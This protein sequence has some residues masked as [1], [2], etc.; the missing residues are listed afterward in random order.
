MGKGR[1][2]ACCYGGCPPSPPILAGTLELQPLL[3]DSVAI[4]TQRDTVLRPPPDGDPASQPLLPSLG[5]THF[6]WGFVDPVEDHKVTASTSTPGL[7]SGNRKACVGGLPWQRSR[8]QWLRI[9]L[10]KQG[11]QVRPLP[12]GLRSHM[13]PWPRKPKRKNRSKIVTHSTKTLKMVH[14]NTNNN[15]NNNNTLQKRKGIGTKS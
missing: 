1:G 6:F 14:I 3:H 10:P 8:L 11:V 4:P 2:P 13:P 12:E 9:R 7:K 15:Y 5:G